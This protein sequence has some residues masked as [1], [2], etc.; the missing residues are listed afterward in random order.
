MLN[1]GLRNRLPKSSMI[2]H[3]SAP[4]AQLAR[5]GFSGSLFTGNGRAIR[6]HRAYRIAIQLCR[7]A[8]THE[9]AIY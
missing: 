8:A 9:E 1:K 6:A 2:T 3:Y 5:D 7:L 4:I